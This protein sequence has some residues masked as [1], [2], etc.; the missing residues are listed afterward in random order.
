MEASMRF[1]FVY[2]ENKNAGSR[3]CS[4]THAEEQ[5]I[6][7]EMFDKAKNGEILLETG[8]DRRKITFVKEGNTVVQRW[9]VRKW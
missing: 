8:N 6:T 1:T 7:Q 9:T 4:S 2:E 3:T 5:Q